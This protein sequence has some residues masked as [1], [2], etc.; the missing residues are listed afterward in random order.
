MGYK[1]ALVKPGVDPFPSSKFLHTTTN[2]AGTQTTLNSVTHLYLE[3]TDGFKYEPFIENKIKRWVN[4]GALAIPLR[5]I[6]RTFIFN[7]I[8]L[9]NLVDDAKARNRQLFLE[10]MVSEWP[11]ATGTP[12]RLSLVF[13]ND[14][15]GTEWVTTYGGSASTPVFSTYRSSAFTRSTILVEKTPCSV[16]T[17]WNLFVDQIVV[18]E[19]WS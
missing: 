12:P 13:F 10:Y 5:S 11:K 16:D 4:K 15:D 6:Y 9:G 8:F 3:P 18:T 14:A 17:N 19:V 1:I 2:E 7:R